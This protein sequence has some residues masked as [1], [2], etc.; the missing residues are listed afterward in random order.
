MSEEPLVNIIAIKDKIISWDHRDWWKVF[1]N[2][3]RAIIK[4]VVIGNGSGDRITFDTNWFQDWLLLKLLGFPMKK[5]TIVWGEMRTEGI[6]PSN[7]NIKLV[8][9]D[10][11]LK[12]LEKLLEITAYWV[13]RISMTAR[14]S[15]MDSRIEENQINLTRRIEKLGRYSGVNFATR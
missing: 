12:S 15:V 5:G 10:V 11:G 3:M 14:S 7:S 9:R 2:K 1:S 6:H 8:L 4:T 13:R